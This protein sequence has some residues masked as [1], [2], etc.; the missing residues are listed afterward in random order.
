MPKILKKRNFISLLYVLSV[1]III[2]IF[3][4]ISLPKRIVISNQSKPN[5]PVG[6]IYG[7]RKIGQTFLAEHNDLSG[8][9]VLLAT[10]NRK[11]SGGFIFHL[12]SDVKSEE[13]IYSFP[14][15]MSTVQDNEF[16]RFSFPK[17]KNSKR[18]KYF[19]YIDAPKS[20]P[21]NA[22]TIWSNSKDLYKEGEKVVNGFVSEGDLV[23]KTEYNLG[24]RLNFDNFLGNII[25]FNIFFV[26]IIKNR[27]LYF[28]LLLVIFIWAFISFSKKVVIFNKKAGFILVCCI[29]LMT[30]SIWIFVSFSKK[31]AIF[32]QQKHN[33]PVG[34]IY[35]DRKIG[36]TFL[37]EY[38]NLSAIEVLLATYKRKNSG[39]LIFH[40][41]N[42]VSS[43]EDL[44]NYKGDINKVKDNKYFNFEFPKIKGSKG[45]KFYFY[46]EAPKSQPGNAITI[47][48][49]FK[50]SYK[51]GEKIVNGAVSEGDLVFKTA[52]DT[53]LKNNLN[54]FLE[55]I[56]Q[57]K[58]FPLNK[59]LFYIILILLF[60]LST[61]LFMTFL[62]KFVIEG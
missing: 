8:I 1:I 30:V 6:E 41:K 11:N 7:D 51:E 2:I 27:V 10:Y 46:L 56:T 15:D 35:G 23:F 45:K 60:V 43:K 5:I 32:N 19:F 24:I 14:G 4:S 17:I 29:L 40:L 22:I 16:Y 38:N 53:G 9:E 59:K 55:R 20:Q 44:F 26:N 25:K 54:I 34:E 50:D 12:K 13:D 36:Q 33:I 18:K 47:W 39:E 61:S 52:Y 21:G 48:S 37:A 58:P 31:I 57:N 62:A 28:L 3:F 42:D 49:N